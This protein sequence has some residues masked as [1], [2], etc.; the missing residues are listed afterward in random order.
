VREGEAPA[1][2]D[3]AMARQEPRP[4]GD[5][6]PPIADTAGSPKPTARTTVPTQRAADADELR[7]LLKQ[8]ARELHIVLTGSEPYVLNDAEGEGD[9]TGLTFAGRR[10]VLESADPANLAVIKFKV[11]PAADGKPVAAL[12]L[13]GKPGEPGAAGVTTSVTL[14]G[15]RFDC[16]GGPEAPVVAVSAGDVDKL[17]VERCAFSLPD[18]PTGARPAGAV[19]ILDRESAERPTVTLKDCLFTRGTQAVQLLGRANVYAQHCC[20]GPHGGG[21]IHFR[22]T[23]GP[24]DNGTGTLVRLENC[25]ALLECGAVVWAEDGAGGTIQVGHCLFTRPAG[26]TDDTAGAVLVRQTGAAAGP[27]VYQGLLGLDG[28]S[29][30]NGYYNLAAIWSDETTPAMPRRAATLED[31]RALTFAAREGDR[32]RVPAFRDDAGLEMAQ[33]PWAEAKP[34]AKLAESPRDAFAANPKLARLHLAR[35]QVGLLGALHNVWGPSYPTTEPP[36]DEPLIVRAKIVNPAAPRMDPERGIYT[37][38]AHAV[39]D[40][41]PGDT[42]LV[43][44]TG[45][46]EVE[47]LRLEK[48]D[49]RLTIAAFPR[50]RPALTLA[51]AA[52]PDAAMFRL[53]DGELR[54]EGLEFALRPGRTEY[55]SQ[56]VVAIAG[57]GS[58]TF[59]ECVAT[60]EEIEGVTLACASIPEAVSPPSMTGGKTTP[61]IRFET[62]FIRGKG[63]LLAARGGRRFEL[64]LDSSLA[65]LDGSLVVANGPAREPNGGGPAQVRLRRSTAVVT[66]HVLDLRALRDDEG[67]HGSGPPPV[68]VACEDTLLA[69]ANGRALVRVDGADGDEQVRQLLAWTAKQTI[70]ANTGSALVELGS[71]SPDRMPP[72]MPFDAEKWLA[73]T[74]ATDATAFA[75]VKFATPP[76]PDKPWAKCR[77]ADFRPKATDMGRPPDAVADV[78]AP[79][80]GLPVSSVD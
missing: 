77:P 40:A 70:Y 76:G 62:C 55:R 52:E 1:E 17:E 10:L 31:A 28:N 19:V 25:S 75:R 59:H 26:E 53:L 79:L 21:L 23:G 6:R 45:P 32:R 34:L 71:T 33:S 58:C 13:T 48:P 5:A 68:A 35:S 44:K 22:D 66:E 42:I 78:G 63:D 4:P 54:L 57:G 50:Y 14:R 15:L 51:P 72:S 9:S 29:Q 43:Q 8:D 73:F 80:D 12:A 20:F 69:A 46:L 16:D 74:R 3:S 38:L 47:P 39:L 18:Q 30:R 61:R 49:L 24:D 7:D 67:K 64:D 56:A 65:A 2:P 41:K 37:S 36:A 11:A 60:L 27:L